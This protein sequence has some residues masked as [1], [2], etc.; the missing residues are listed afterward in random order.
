MAKKP[1]SKASVKKP[2]VAEAV[3]SESK[4]DKDQAPKVSKKVSKAKSNGTKKF[5]KFQK[6]GSAK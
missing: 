5:D 3:A 2:E 4:S 6:R 1:S